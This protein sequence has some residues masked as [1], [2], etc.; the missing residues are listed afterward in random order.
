MTRNPIG[1][2]QR[3]EPACLARVGLST[4]SIKVL[5]CV[6]GTANAT[7]ETCCGRIAQALGVGP[8]DYEVVSGLSVKSDVPR[9]WI[10]HSLAVPLD[11]DPST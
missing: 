1:S 10:R 11:W 9:R 2:P 3:E 7:W 5:S 6:S 4:S 8:E